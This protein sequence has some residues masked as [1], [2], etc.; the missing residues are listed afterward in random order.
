MFDTSSSVHGF[1]RRVHG[2]SRRAARRLEAQARLFEPLTE[3]VLRRAGV[4]SGMRVLDAG[5]GAGAVSMLAAR[6]VGDDGDVTGI[7]VSARAVAAAAAAARARGL[8]NVRFERR[9]FGSL[10]A[11]RDFDAVIGRFVLMHVADP[12]AAIWRLAGTVRDGGILA[13]QEF[14]FTQQPMSRPFV[15]PAAEATRWIAETLARSGVDI[16]TGMRLRQTF[17]SAGLRA[18]EMI[19]ASAVQGGVDSP[20]Y[21]LLG[22]T[23]RDL[24]HPMCAFGIATRDEVGIESLAARIRQCVLENDAV[25]ESPNV[26][27]AWTS[28]DRSGRAF[29]PIGT[30]GLSPGRRPP[31]RP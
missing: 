6:L 13:F 26:V 11:T 31:I 27:G 28:V 7:D 1:S 22:D 20:I 19:V 4:T 5:C 17:V 24:L 16:G 9:N 18:P 21:D 10:A 15:A 23:V 12:V 14:D 25:L 29:V 2:S 3:F 30:T 8:R